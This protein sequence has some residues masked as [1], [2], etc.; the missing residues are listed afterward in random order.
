MAEICFTTMVQPAGR[1]CKS[2][3]DSLRIEL[4]PWD[5]RLLLV[6]PIQKG[7]LFL[8]PSLP[9]EKELVANTSTTTLIDHLK[10]SLS[11]TL[12]FFPPLAG[13]LGIIEKADNTTSFFI[14]CNDVGAQFI[15]AVAPSIAVANI[16]EPVYV[17]RFV[18]SF[19]PLNGVQNH[20]GVSKPLLAVQ[21]TELADG[22]FIGSTVNHAV[23]DGSS[24]WHFFNSWSEISGGFDKITRPPFLER[25]F[26]ND[27]DCPIRVPLF[28]KQLN[29]GFYSIL[30]K[31]QERVFHFTKEK[32]TGLKE[33]A[34]AEMKYTTRISS[35]QALMAFLWRSII[36]CTSTV[37]HADEETNFRVAIGVRPRLHPPLPQEYFGNGVYF[38]TVTTKASELLEQ[39]QGW[40]AWQMNKLI[41]SQTGDEIRN[42]LKCWVKNPRLPTWGSVTTNALIT[43]SSPR[44]NMYGNDFG[45]GKPVAV[46]SGEAN[47]CDG[48]LTFFQGPEEGSIDVEICLLPETLHAMEDDA[49]FME[50]IT[51]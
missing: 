44:F 38:E 42:F 34:N 36:R 31:L 1:H 37:V 20:E 50:V 16:L 14:N 21:V 24:F 15:Y 30:P 5:V 49:E 22:F 25:W 19:F 13:R 18:H 7:L 40:A 9:Q 29:E 47:K 26:P 17:P 48:K 45:W 3:T 35:L 43:S 28:D 33:K 10:T 12:D 23:A 2:S 41:A 11:R 46:R 32:I 6:G 8:K 51:V 27:I 4:T 39:G